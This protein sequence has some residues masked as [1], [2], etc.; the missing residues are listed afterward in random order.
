[1]LDIYCLILDKGKRGKK[2][3]PILELLILATILLING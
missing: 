3:F 1:M 2:L